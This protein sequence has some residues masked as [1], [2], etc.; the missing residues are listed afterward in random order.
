M[1]LSELMNVSEV[2]YEYLQPT[3]INEPSLRSPQSTTRIFYQS[4][5]NNQV[6]FINMFSKNGTN[7]NQI[8][9]PMLKSSLKDD[10]PAVSIP[11][12]YSV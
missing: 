3:Q 11:P 5:K 12:N 9:N 6:P 1:P 10:Q 8:Y 7:H 4:L 2:V